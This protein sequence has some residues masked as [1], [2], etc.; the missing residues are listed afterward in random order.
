MRLIAHRELNLLSNGII[1]PLEGIFG[2]SMLGGIGYSIYGRLF[3]NLTI[4]SFELV[5]G[6]GEIIEEFQEAH[7]IRGEN[8]REERKLNNILER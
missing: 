4:Q 7:I 1:A 6:Q 8:E 2:I 3:I 5:Q